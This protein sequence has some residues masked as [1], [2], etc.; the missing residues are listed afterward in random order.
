[1]ICSDS[2]NELLDKRRK[3]LWLIWVAFVFAIIVYAVVA[4]LVTQQ[5][6]K[7]ASPVPGEVLSII[8]LL[9]IIAGAVSLLI[10]RLV[11]SEKRIT[12]MLRSP[13]SLDR[14]AKN[15]N[16]RVDHALL[17]KLKSLRPLE[18]KLY[19][20][21]TT[22][23]RWFIIISALPEVIAIFG[24]ISAFFTGSFTDY[25]YFGLPAILLEILNYPTKLDSILETAIF[26]NQKMSS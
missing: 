5:P 19:S 1:M 4:Y 13:I 18:Q 7:M 10:P 8:I 6:I 15:Q 12:Q 2:L 16:Q 24:F 22:Y 23:L 11:F 21:A 14:L 3:I 26:L 9:A 17:E 20:I 25:F